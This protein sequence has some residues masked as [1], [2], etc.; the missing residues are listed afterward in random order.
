MSE[1]RFNW[2]SSA[3]WVCSVVRRERRSVVSTSETADRVLRIDSR[4][5][6]KLARNAWYR[7][8][9]LMTVN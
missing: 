7:S 9:S 3:L 8:A 4:C 2:S 1:A 5:S 6:A